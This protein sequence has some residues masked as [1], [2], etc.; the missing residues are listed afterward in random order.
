MHW[1]KDKY[2]KCFIYLHFFSFYFLGYHNLIQYFVRR[3]H[4]SLFHK[5]KGYIHF[6]R[7][8]LCMQGAVSQA[9]M[10]HFV[11]TCTYKTGYY[12]H[13][14]TLENVALMAKA[15]TS[16]HGCQFKLSI[17]EC[18]FTSIC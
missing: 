2:N 5:V 4:G 17:R 9:T 8:P 11:N 18:T 7:F 3:K 15:W 12:R 13:A 6:P 1:S 14:A 10:L 16:T